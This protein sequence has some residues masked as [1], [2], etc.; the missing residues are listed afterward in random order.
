MTCRHDYKSASAVD[1]RVT[2]L[3]QLMT[4]LL[5]LLPTV[6]SLHTDIV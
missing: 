5:P 6:N 1:Q 2:G 3:E 4:P